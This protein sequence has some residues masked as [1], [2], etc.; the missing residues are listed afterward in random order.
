MRKFDLRSPLAHLPEQS[1]Q[2]MW[3]NVKSSPF[4]ELIRYL[5]D[6][7]AEGLGVSNLLFNAGGNK[8]QSEVHYQTF[9]IGRVRPIQGSNSRWIAAPFDRLL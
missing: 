5:N 2:I 8:S 4:M 7:I 3:P 6:D 9:K 1:V